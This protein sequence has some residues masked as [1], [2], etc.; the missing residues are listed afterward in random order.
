MQGTGKQQRRPVA[1]VTGA[2]QG[3]GL[4]LAEALAHRGWSLVV[5]ARRADR[6]AAAVTRLEV[7]TDVI[8]VAGDVSEPDHR[9]A[10]VRAAAAAGPVR[11]VVNNASTLG[12]SP[13][14]MLT[15]LTA[16]VLRRTFEVNVLAPLALLRDLDS[17]L[18][19]GATVVNITSDAAVEAYAGWGAVRRVEG[20]ARAG[21]RDPRGRAPGPARVGG[22]PGRHAHRD[23]PGRVP[24]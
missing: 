24:R 12:A 6:L 17:T 3:L 18:T 15:D 14:P 8:A 9:A 1:V 13:L 2:S 16:D 10:L 7:L 11:L 22:R 20:R 19:P 5:D 21:Q 4:A 23:A